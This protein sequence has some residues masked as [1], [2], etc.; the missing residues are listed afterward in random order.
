MR[1]TALTLKNF[2]GIDERGVRIDFAPITLLFGPNNAGK[3]T[4]IQAL[5]LAR[6]VLYNNN[7]DPDRV[8]GGGESINLGGFKEFVHKHDLHRTVSIGLEI[9]LEGRDLPPFVRL[10]AMKWQELQELFDEYGHVKHKDEKCPYWEKLEALSQSGLS[11]T[12]WGFAQEALN[13]VSSIRVELGLSWGM[14]TKRPFVSNYTIAIDGIALGGISCKESGPQLFE[15]IEFSRLLSSQ[16]KDQCRQYIKV[17]FQSDENNDEAGDGNVELPGLVELLSGIINFDA[18][19]ETLAPGSTCSDYCQA[20]PEIINPELK[21]SALPLWDS[22]LDVSEITASKVCESFLSSLLVGPG[23]LLRELLQKQ[24]LYIGPLRAIPPRNFSPVKTV[25]HD[26]WANG[27]ATWDMLATATNDQ[28]KAVNHRLN[29]P[30][31][32]T[33]GYTVARKRSLPLDADGPLALALRRSL[34]EDFDENSLPLLRAF[35]EQSPEIRILLHN[36]N[37]GVEVEPQDMGVGI[38]QIIPTVVAAVFPKRD[39]IIAIE[40]PELHIHPAW[41]TALGDIF[42]QAVHKEN[43]PVF[44]LE[45]HSEHLLLR[46]LRRIRNTYK[47]IASEG[48]S[49]S[50]TDLA[51]HWIGTYDGRTE[52]Y[53]LGLDEDGSFN[54][55][56]PEG[57]FDERGEELF[58]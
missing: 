34:L 31:F 14:A 49:L 24:L 56:W 21:G 16:E 41:Q 18:T 48:I 11:G 38:S 25:V 53:R 43:P 23:L 4:V 33:T 9:D 32:L 26:R 27:M 13:R 36:E 15:G 10:E 8:E 57:F 1:L 39:A 28:L 40:Q 45:T 29:S 5:H 54:T 50:H 6:E 2:K 17:N 58:G 12:S 37:T 51:V 47:G 3:S 44:L 19:W 42:I 35:L 46:L 55:P 22:P 52:I 7:F 30:D 20:E